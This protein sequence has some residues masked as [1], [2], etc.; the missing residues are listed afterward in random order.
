MRYF[1]LACMALLSTLATVEGNAQS[2]A[3]TFKQVAMA[4]DKLTAVQYDSYREIN[5]YKDNYFAKNSGSSYFDFDPTADG[6]VSR[7]QLRSE[8]MFQVYN[9]TEYFVLNESN[10]TAEF[11]KRKAQSLGNLSL[12]FNSIATLRISLP[13]VAG[14]AAI[15]K[16]VKDT[17]IEGRVY[18]LLKFELHKKT[19]EFPKGFSSFEVDVTR[20]YDLVV[21]KKT[22]FP[23]IIIDRNSL[24]KDQYFTKTVFTN[25][26]TK[27]EKP[28]ASSWFFSSYTG[29]SPKQSVKQKPLVAV[30]ASMP[31]WILPE[32]KEG[33]TDSVG[34]SAF[35][36]KKVLME[37]WIK[38]CGYCM[39]AFP[40][41][42]GLQE[43][44]GKSVDI[45]SVNAYD[46]RKE[47]DFFYK[48]EKPAY[49]MLYNGEK[50][51][52]DLGIYGYPA[53]VILDESG[54]VIYSHSGFNKEQIEAVL[55]K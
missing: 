36:G 11:E 2:A 6:K 47:I 34:Q 31:Q 46:D 35:K 37:F 25:I 30:G 29:Y 38:N 33:A 54:K 40:E 48:R 45:L 44:Y 5:N 3:I 32:Y 8:K 12:L 43:K 51:A 16:S 41:M 53:F 7:F 19:I 49:K 21:D 26:E 22:L 4:L 52:N 15:P 50:L 14:D 17:T 39:L 28:A 13:V 20:Y 1:L 23:Y 9:G 55:G 42:K 18:H 10:K 24:M 27:P